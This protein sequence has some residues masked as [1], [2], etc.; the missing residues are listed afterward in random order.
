MPRDSSAFQ[1]FPDAPD[2]AWLG[3][4]RSAGSLVRF[5][6]SLEEVGTFAAGRL[7]YLATP[8]VEFDGGRA[9]AAAHAG[10][11]QEQLELLDADVVSPAVRSWSAEERRGPFGTLARPLPNWWGLLRSA[12]LVVVPPMEGWGRSQD[13]WGAVR[14]AVRSNTP[15][16]VVG[17]AG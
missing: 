6:Q 7:A 15:V 13:V 17:G 8:Y 9:L 12:Q 16:L 1:V 4:H 11:W 10:E 2:W 5:G 3:R 14:A